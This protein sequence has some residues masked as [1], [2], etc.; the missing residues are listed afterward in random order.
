M[1]AADG[2]LNV[3]PFSLPSTANLSDAGA[4][5]IYLGGKVI[6]TVDQKAGAYSGD[7]VLTVAYNGT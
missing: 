6:P 2:Y 5:N 7:I 3:N 4:A 1:I